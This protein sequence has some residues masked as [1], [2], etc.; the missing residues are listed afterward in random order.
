MLKGGVKHR[1][2]SHMLLWG[3]IMIMTPVLFAHGNECGALVQLGPVWSW[4][5][6]GA[7]A[8]VK[9]GHTWSWG[10]CGAG[11]RVDLLCSLMF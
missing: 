8:R 11:A 4:G 1:V 7:R 9:L 10:L 3:L 5:T 6:C 2:S